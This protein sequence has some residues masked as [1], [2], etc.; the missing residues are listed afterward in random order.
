VNSFSG[1]WRRRRLGK[2]PTPPRRSLRRERVDI[3]AQQV[4]LSADI[5]TSV[6]G[7]MVVRFMAATGRRGMTF[8]MWLVLGF[9]V[10]A[11]TVAVLSPLH[12][13]LIRAS[14]G[15]PRGRSRIKVGESGDVYVEHEAPTSV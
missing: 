13:A 9:F 4:R 8:D 12:R 10:L 2:G 11:V 7:I 15:H 1:T 5:S 3:G 14:F 6:A